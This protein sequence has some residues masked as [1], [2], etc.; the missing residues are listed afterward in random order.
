MT[1]DGS[2]LKRAI[3][4]DEGF[5]RF[6][7][8]DSVG[9]VTIG[10]GHNLTDN[11]LPLPILDAIYEHDVNSAVADCNRLLQ[12]HWSRLDDVRKAVIINMMFNLGL[13][14]L[15]LFKKMIAAIKQQDWSAAARE[16]MDSKWAR[17]VGPRAERLAHML[18]TGTWHPFYSKRF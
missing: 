14:K 15:S 4:L 2:K 3:E 5:R 1:L 8:V 6:P 7:Y 9:K 11:G 16:A 18:K 13:G 17:Q 12:D 10:I